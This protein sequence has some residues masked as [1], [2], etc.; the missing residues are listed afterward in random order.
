M[1]LDA[2][3]SFLRRSTSST[4]LSFD[5]RPQP[6]SSTSSS[7]AGSSWSSQDKEELAQLLAG[8]TGTLRSVY[9]IFHDRVSLTTSRC[10]AFRV[11]EVRCSRPSLS[12]STRMP[13]V[14]SDEMGRRRKGRRRGV[15]PMIRNRTQNTQNSDTTSRRISLQPLK[16]RIS[17]AALYLPKERRSIPPRPILPPSSR[18]RV[19]NSLPPPT[20]HLLPPLTLP[21]LHPPPRSTPLASEHL[22]IALPSST[23]SRKQTKT[24]PPFPNRTRFEWSASLP[25]PS[26][27]TLSSASSA[28]PLGLRPGTLSETSSVG[29]RLMGRRSLRE[30]LRDREA[31]TAAIRS[32]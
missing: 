17:D 13:S 20:L 8:S 1:R 9:Q 19:F 5:C 14:G 12:F 3:I 18:R 24:N 29:E 21:L 15:A 7:K 6:S 32:I 22:P 25:P 31:A 27:A 4:T 2:E 28:E 16:P 11:I 26:L 10:F 30:L 23:P